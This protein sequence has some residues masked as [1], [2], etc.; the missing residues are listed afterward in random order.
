MP[1][2]I[3]GT[4]WKKERSRELVRQAL[5]AGFRGVDTAAQPKHYQEDQVGL[6][7]NDAIRE[8]SLKRDEI[9][10]QTKYTSINGQDPNKMPYDPKISISEQ[11]YASVASSLENFGSAEAAYIDCLVLHSPF[12]TPQQTQEAWRAMESHV[13]HTVRSL[14]ISNIYHLPGLRAL[15]DSAT[16]K[17]VVVQNRF[18]RD[19]G[20]DADVRAFCA[21]KGIAYQSFWTLTANPHL[22]RLQAVAFVAQN[23]GVSMQV[24]L[25]GLVLG[26]GKVSILDGTTNAGRMV[27]DL[28]GVK[29]IQA[30]RETEPK[31]WAKAQQAFEAALGA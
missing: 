23:A 5:L 22:L 3:Y 1:A 24:A 26:L 28:E 10:V 14:G 30:W 25:Y 13:P 15:Y 2:L 12:P 16:V 9:Y 18:H 19:T 7:I 20:Y 21:E 6:G 31:N 27:E 4:A 29:L 17:P 8:G 11:A